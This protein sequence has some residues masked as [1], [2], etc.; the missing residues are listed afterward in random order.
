MTESVPAPATPS[1]DTKS[2]ADHLRAIEFDARM[3]GM[4]AALAAIWLGFNWLSGGAFLTPRNL[5]N[6]S[7]QSASVAS[8]AACST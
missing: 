4:I 2:F 5:W 7:V 8:L 3:I 6:L 1:Q